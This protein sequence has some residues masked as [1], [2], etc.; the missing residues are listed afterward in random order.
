M[1]KVQL[2]EEEES[3]GSKG[4]WNEKRRKKKRID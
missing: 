2:E 4:V 1:Q 3:D